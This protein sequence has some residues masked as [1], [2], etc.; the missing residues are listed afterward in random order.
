[1]R[2]GDK[3]M[4]KIIAACLLAALFI[5]PVMSQ[6]ILNAVRSGDME[7]VKSLL[8]E[9]PDLIHTKD[10]YHN[11]LLYLALLKDDFAM[12]RFLIES[13][14]DVNYSR[15]DRGGNELSGAI[16]VGSL[17]ITK[18]ILE[19]GADIHEKNLRG[20]T[21]LDVAIYENEKEI[22]YFL[23]DKGAKLNVEEMGVSSLMRAS[24]SGGLERITNKLI[25]EHEVDFKDKNSSGE[26]FLHAAAN[27]GDTAFIGLLIERDL[28]PNTKNVYGWAPLHYA[29]SEGH[30]NMVEALVKNKAEK[31]IRTKDGKNP[32]NIAQELG[33]KDLIQ[34]LKEKGTT[35][36]STSRKQKPVGAIV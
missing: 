5:L 8:K 19:K 1:M 31:N 7:K 36:S 23:M 9:N 24:L 14:I 11:S 12:A 2:V 4:K 30:R 34:Y 3:K 6:D 13:G 10:Q 28:D 20:I 35:I 32:Y 18:L 26:T 25:Q 21:P 33:Q 17:E 29:A 27:G 15:K 22:A 16:M